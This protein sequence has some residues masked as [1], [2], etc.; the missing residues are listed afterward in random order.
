LPEILAEMRSPIAIEMI[1]DKMPT[2]LG[3]FH[4]QK[5][6]KPTILSASCSPPPPATASS[7][8]I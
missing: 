6:P 4:R 5:S 2:L 7:T 3:C 1:A 8:R